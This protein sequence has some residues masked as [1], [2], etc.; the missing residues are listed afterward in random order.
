MRYYRR[1]AYEND[2]GIEPNNSLRDFSAHANVNAPLGTDDRLLDEP[3]LRRSVDAPRRGQ[4]CVGAARRAVADIRCCSRRSRGFYPGFPPD[5]PQTLYDN[6]TG[7]NRFTG[8]ATLNNRPT[9]WFTQRAVLGVDYTAE[10]ARAI[11]HFAP[12]ALAAILS[13]AAAGGRIGQTLRRNDA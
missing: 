12:P 8:S 10:D 9:N 1:S 7:V 4:R 13:P 2:Y 6:A 3:Q 5:V 11:E